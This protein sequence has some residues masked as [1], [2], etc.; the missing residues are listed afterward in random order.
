MRKPFNTCLINKWGIANIISGGGLLSIFYSQCHMPNCLT[1]KQDFF[2]W[3]CHVLQLKQLTDLLQVFWICEE[4][5]A[6]H[7]SFICTYE[8]LT[9]WASPTNW[10][11]YH[12]VSWKYYI[13]PTHWA[14]LINN[15]MS[16]PWNLTSVPQTGWF[17]CHKFHSRN[18]YFLN[19]SVEAF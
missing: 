18:Q 3:F 12:K 19:E 1:V 8:R 15:V 11:C 2:Q 17:C 13:I 6:W 9:N 10:A 4:Y 16:F 5:W 7:V 14:I